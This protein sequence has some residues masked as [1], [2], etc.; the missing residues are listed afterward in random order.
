M[1]LVLAGGVVA[2]RTSL[3]RTSHRTRLWLGMVGTALTAPWLLALGWW[4]HTGLLVV[5]AAISGIGMGYWDVA[6]ETSLQAHVS[7]AQL[8]RV[9][10]WF[11]LGALVAVPIGQV[12]TGPIAELGVPPRPGWRSSCSWPRCCHWRPGRCA[13]CPRSVTGA[14]LRPPRDRRPGCR[15]L[16]FAPRH[17]R[18]RPCPLA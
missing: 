6:W 12:A 3:A 1:A 8:A 13:G 4:P 17:G 18:P 14:R 7:T 9:S 10:S 2:D 16:G 5:A 15:G 11:Q